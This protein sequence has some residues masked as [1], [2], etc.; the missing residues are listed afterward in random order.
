MRQVDTP[1]GTVSTHLK[2]G[3]ARSGYDAR[4]DVRFIAYTF[5]DR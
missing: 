2:P 3:H 1:E 4:R 5:G